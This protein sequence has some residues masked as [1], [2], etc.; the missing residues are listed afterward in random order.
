MPAPVPQ[1]RNAGVERTPSHTDKMLRSRLDLTTV[2]ITHAS[3]EG[4]FLRVN[5][6]FCRIVGYTPEELSKLSF[7]QVTCPADLA[8]DVAQAERLLSGEA[9]TYSL[10]KRYVH[11]DGHLEWVALTVSLARDTQGVPEYF[12]AVCEPI[13]ER[14]IF[15]IEALAS[16]ARHRVLLES[17]AEGMFVCQDDRLVFANLAFPA[18]LGCSHHELMEMSFE[19]FVAPESLRTWYEQMAGPDPREAVP[20]GSHELR[21]LSRARPGGLWLELRVTVTQFDSRA[22]VLGVVRDV[23][24]RKQAE[25]ATRERG[26]L[27][28]QLATIAAAS[29]GVIHAFRRRPD[30]SISFPY[31]NR[32]AESIFGLK[33]E[34]LLR[35]AR[36]LRALMPAE[37]RASVESAV[38][39]SARDMTPL[40]LEY[41]V[42]HPVKG[43]LWVE[44]RS[45][46]VQE[47]DGSIIWHGY[48]HDITGRKRAEGELLHYAAIIES[49]QDAIVGKTTSGIVTSWNAG[50]E[51]TFGYSA[52]EMLGRSINVI[53][54]PDRA[55]EE[56]MILACI[57]RG[58]SVKH[59]ETVRQR[60]DG[61]L[62]DVSVTISPL[63]DAQGRIVG[64]SKIAR[65][66][67][68]SKRAAQRA[69]LQTE[70][71]LDL[72]HDAIIILDE[73]G[74]IVYWNLGAEGLYGW[75]SQE[76][77]G[78]VSH[79]LLHTA[80]TSS[81][82]PDIEDLCR[83]SDHWDGELQRRR[84][85]GSILT[86]LSRWTVQRDEAG[87]SRRFLEIDR[88]ITARKRAEMEVAALNEHLRARSAE[89]EAYTYSVS[90]DLKAPLRGIEGY[91][92]LLLE[93]HAGQLDPEGRFFLQS[94]RKA[95]SR[96]EELIDDLLDY[97]RVDR[98]QMTIHSVELAPLVEALVDERRDEIKTTG[99]E[100]VVSFVCPSVAAETEGLSL[101]LRNLLDNALKFSRESRPPR[102]EIGSRSGD[103]RALVWIRDNG[104]G[105]DMRFH[106]KIFEI[107]QRLH[108]SD[109]YPGTG[110]GLAIVRKAIERM[111]GRV[112]AEAA[113]STG[114]TFFLDLPAS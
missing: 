11:K 33:L 72:A 76:A 20:A 107:F 43:E 59:F 67:T 15:A 105:F 51:R 60:K 21:F 45:I 5:S 57:A 77:V 1:D 16:E 81:P 104:I 2:G 103:G 32:A 49:S 69:L 83:A 113:P 96:M 19:Q 56:D 99:A 39:V 28:R 98:G 82:L 47:E 10:D 93:D 94:I 40:H 80:A 84:R 106:D 66:I 58:K 18:M 25:Q 89:L 90:H 62:I 42:Q 109:K 110:I 88:D 79:S 34:E 27:E 85:D 68:E 65:D 29:P 9:D 35:D 71:I 3:P 50:A 38:A 41:R 46:P 36:S 75:K 97:S 4:R 44:A 8:R 24:E 78:K 70:A 111:H 26:A 12:I 14:R 74:T 61:T 48:L 54:P 108:A 114:A 31:I 112:W 37:D 102:I 13:Q 73:L 63:R 86:V 87:R 101:V 23:T 7:H 53:I 30:G 95:A 91:S 22:A 64:A 6:E 52:A 92:R 100:L 55:A 17:L